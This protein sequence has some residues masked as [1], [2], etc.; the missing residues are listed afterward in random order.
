VQLFL[1]ERSSNTPARV[2]VRPA[3]N[4]PGCRLGWG[5]SREQPAR[6]AHPWRSQSSRRMGRI[7]QTAEKWVF[8][9]LHVH[10]APASGR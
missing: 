4:T 7:D 8:A 6:D 10:H 1:R 2:G 3:L 5:S 9:S